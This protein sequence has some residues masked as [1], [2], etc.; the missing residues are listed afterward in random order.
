VYRT[1]GYCTG[2]TYGRKGGNEAQRGLLSPSG[3][4]DNEAR[5]I[6][7]PPEVRDNEARTIGRLWAQEPGKGEGVRFNVS[8]RSCAGV[9]INVSY[10]RTRAHG[11][12]GGVG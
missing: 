1:V 7:L 12:E 2:C 11:R 6:S 10:A 5:L 3:K 8:Y 4:K 9:K